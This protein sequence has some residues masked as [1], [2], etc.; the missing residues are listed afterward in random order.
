[1]IATPAAR[2]HTQPP[3][4]E[5]PPPLRRLADQI[6]GWLEL[7]C[8]EKALELIGPL[9]ADP[10]ARAAGLVMRIR[11]VIRQGD[12]RAALHDLGELRMVQP[13]DDWVELTEAWCRK[14]TGELPLAIVC[15]E[16]LLAKN[17]KS[18]IGHFNLACYLA[19][20]GATE[21]AIDELSLA[22]GLDPGLR[23]LARDEPD[24][25]QLRNDERFRQLL[26]SAP[27][28]GEP[29]TLPDLDD[30]LDDDDDDDEP[31]DAG[32]GPDPR[33]N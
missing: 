33:R 4:S 16:R 15:C 14:R 21:R 2:R 20:S 8:P 24:F 12:Y 29:P 10:A 22:C 31:E 28:D 1:M 18:D 30:G 5:I 23:D 13:A 9:L 3:V 17:H 11:A 7:R 19:L 32:H 26:R 6:D 27:A 25:D